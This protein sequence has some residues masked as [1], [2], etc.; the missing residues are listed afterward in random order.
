M[1]RFL[2][3][4]LLFA[5]VPLPA[6]AQDD[7]PDRNNPVA[8][9]PDQNET[10]SSGV[11]PPTFYESPTFGYVLPWDVTVWTENMSDAGSDG[12]VLVLG[13]QGD[14]VTFHGYEGQAGDPNAC[15]TETV[16]QL[17]ETL[18]V[19]VPPVDDTE[20]K[21]VEGTDELRAATMFLIDSYVDAEGPHPEAV[22]YLECRRLIPG[23]AVLAITYMVPLDRY[24]DLVD[25]AYLLI[26]SVVMPR[27]SY[28]S[29]DI[30]SQP[31]P[32]DCDFSSDL[33]FDFPMPP[34]LLLGGSG[35]E[36]GMAAVV[37]ERGLYPDSPE[38]AG[39]WDLYVLFE[40]TGS[41]ALTINPLGVEVTASSRFAEGENGC[42]AEPLRPSNFHWET[43]NGDPTAQVRTIEPGERLIAR[44]MFAEPFFE[45]APPGF[46]RYVAVYEPEQNPPS[47][48]GAWDEP[49]A[50]T[51]RP[52][53]S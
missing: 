33:P 18:V 44:L 13:R 40:N 34:R 29:D 17:D 2:L 49:A 50:G 9:R 43:G 24:E 22:W 47:I 45:G 48:I 14:T 15:L 36:I 3:A 23:S 31:V 1:R 25:S 10:N 26:N 32:E 30:D 16:A 51:G 12:D 8:G 41:E 39:P 6:Y 20:G 7:V 46:N 38:E 37:E 27:K 35:E 52:R 11:D 42:K 4:L 5:A 21:R 28:Y 53:L 19:G